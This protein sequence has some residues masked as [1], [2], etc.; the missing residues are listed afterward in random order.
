MTHAQ[1]E[2][3][4]GD[5]SAAVRSIAQAYGFAE[6][7]SDEALMVEVLSVQGDIKRGADDVDGAA[8]DLVSALRAAER[9]SVTD[10]HT[11][12]MTYA[13]LGIVRRTQGSPKEAVDSTVARS[14]RAEGSRSPSRLSDGCPEQP[15]ER[16]GRLSGFP[17]R[18]RR[19]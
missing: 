3:R 13:R 2:Q 18:D 9:A 11:L 5:H 14:I 10:D 16:S 4:V 6:Q 8:A 19:A 17:R 1:I 12:G 7:V 15:R